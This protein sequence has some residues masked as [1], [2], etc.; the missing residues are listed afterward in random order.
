[1]DGVQ[2][3][4]SML[5]AILILS[6]FIL[7]FTDIP[8]KIQF[9]R[10]SSVV[11]RKLMELI[12]FEEEGRRK[13][14]KYLKD[15]NL[16]NPKTLIDDY[17]DNFFMIF[18]VEREPI[19]VIKRLKHLLRTRDEAVKRYVLDKVPNVSEIDRQRIEVLLELNSVL[20]YINKV[21]KHYYNL[22]VKFNDW[23]MMM[24]L[25]LQINQIVRL[26]KAYRDAIDS[27]GVGA[28]I[29]DGAGA[30]VARMLLGNVSGASEIAP[31]TVLYETSFEGRKL[32]V[33]KAKGPGPT[34]GWPGEALEKLVDSLECRISRII[35]VDAALK[36][37]S[38]K[39]GEVAYGV[40][41]AIGDLGPEKIAME[42]IASR[43]SVPLDAVVIKMSNEEAINTMTKQVYEGVVRA[44]DIVKNTILSKTREGDAVVVVGVG[45]TLGIE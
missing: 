44:A 16:P 22:G 9:T 30:L 27:F 5:I 28:P 11:R 26:A 20:T 19:D 32:Y 13:S 45:N 29:G 38:E 12:E 10:Y 6:S 25:A 14:I 41:A 40:G 1:M 21:V 18:P 17:V 15:M 35:T 42:R 36:L 4:T 34:V 24:Q 7:N 37:E 2:D 23:I 31:E 33:I 43:C 3:W 39:S 8:Q